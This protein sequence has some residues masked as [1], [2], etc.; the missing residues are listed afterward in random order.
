MLYT[1]YSIGMYGIIVMEINT[2]VRTV[3]I[4]EKMETLNSYE[5]NSHKK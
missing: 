2:V 3:L 4:V 5:N 1:K